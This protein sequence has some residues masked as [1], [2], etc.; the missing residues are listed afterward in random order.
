MEVIII[1]L[2]GGEAEI[3]IP[4]EGM[5]G[6]RLYIPVNS[7]ANRLAIEAA[8]FELVEELGYVS[9]PLPAV[10]RSPVAS[11]LAGISLVSMA[12]DRFGS[13]GVVVPGARKVKDAKLSRVVFDTS[14]PAVA[15]QIWI[16]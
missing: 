5:I 12:T 4:I 14:I 10:P 8:A 15:G 11:D 6:K 2:V 1:G 7:G 13:I 3:K 16:I 9:E